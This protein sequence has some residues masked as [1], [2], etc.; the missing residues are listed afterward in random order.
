MVT[1]RLKRR[2]QKGRPSYNVVVADSKK[3]RDGQFIERLGYYNPI[4][5]VVGL[6][7]NRIAHWS[8]R[9]AQLSE[10]VRNLVRHKDQNERG[11]FIRCFNVNN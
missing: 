10:A 3:K 8:E 2:G 1:I 11:W 5:K 4:S 9:G 7:I 6:N